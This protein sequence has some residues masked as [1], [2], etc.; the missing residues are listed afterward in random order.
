MKKYPTTKTYQPLVESIQG[1]LSAV[2][3]E[4]SS[5]E[6]LAAVAAV[7]DDATLPTLIDPDGADTQAVVE[8]FEARLELAT[9]ALDTNLHALVGLVVQ[10][11]LLSEDE[12]AELE[13][14]REAQVAELAQALGLVDGDED[15]PAPKT[16]LTTIAPEG[17]A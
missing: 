17:Q 2:V 15:D 8:T 9:R 3:S 14:E 10:E 5:L 13:R 1:A 16:G 6:T 11:A 4:L 7:H 12:K